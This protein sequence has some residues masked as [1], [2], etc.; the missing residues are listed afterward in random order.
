MSEEV[1]KVHKSALAQCLPLKEQYDQCFNSWYRHK[2]L[3]SQSGGSNCDD[4]FDEY[5]ACLI[6]EVDKHGLGYLNLFGPS[7]PKDP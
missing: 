5:R 6:E 2:F 7:K 3:Q 1:S 4:F